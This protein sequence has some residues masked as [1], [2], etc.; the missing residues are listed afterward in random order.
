ME[1]I[2]DAYVLC[3][4]R[5]PVQQSFSLPHISNPLRNFISKKEKK[6]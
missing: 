2:K 6:G 5:H 1:M 3:A 4:E